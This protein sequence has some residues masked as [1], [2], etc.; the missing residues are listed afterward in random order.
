MP[1]YCLVEERHLSPP[2][3]AGQGLPTYTNRIGFLDFM[4]EIQQ[5]TL[6]FTQYEGLRVE[7]LED[8]L[9]AARPRMDELADHIRQVLQ[10]A[11][12]ALDRKL[13]ADIQIVFHGQLKRGEVLWV[14][15]VTHHRIP[16]HRVFG[17]PSAEMFGNCPFYRASF[18]LSSGF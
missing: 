14:D 7:G 8:V 3:H 17:S 6:G 4:R 12:S 18:N 15:H 1:N 16:I 13:C 11:A 10:H 5:E 2:Q 9:L